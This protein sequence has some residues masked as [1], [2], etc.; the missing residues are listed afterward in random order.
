M[1]RKILAENQDFFVT[2]FSTNF[3]VTEPEKFLNTNIFC[4]S[5]NFQLKFRVEPK[6]FWTQRSICL[7]RNF[8]MK[9]LKQSPK[10]FWTP[11]FFFVCHEIFSWKFHDRNQKISE[12]Q[13]IFPAHHK[14]TGSEI[15][16]QKNAKN[17]LFLKEKRKIIT[18]FFLTKSGNSDFYLTVFFC[19]SNSQLKKCENTFFV[20]N[21]V[22]V[23]KS[24][25]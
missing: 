19:I 23:K 15:R 24:C 21:D 25:F 12:H 5:L 11:R 13:E 1:P 6:K 10:N 7:S 4:L 8:Q 2:K 14:Y 22:S 3:F 16:F 17:R 20:T 9:I 18:V